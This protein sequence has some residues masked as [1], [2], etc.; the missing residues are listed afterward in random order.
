MTQR[1][2]STEATQQEEHRVAQLKPGS[3]TLN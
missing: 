3:N 1:D 2:A